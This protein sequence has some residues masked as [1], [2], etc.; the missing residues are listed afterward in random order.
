M[1]LSTPGAR[2]ALTLTIPND[3]LLVGQT[4][5]TRALFVRSSLPNDARF[6]IVN[7]DKISR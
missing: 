3:A 2:V 6:T 5:F 1:H 7:A 4:V